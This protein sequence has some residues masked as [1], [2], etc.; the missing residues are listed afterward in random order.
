MFTI[1]AVAL[2]KKVCKLLQESDISNCTIEYNYLIRTKRNIYN[3]RRKIFPVLPKSIDDVHNIILNTM[4][5]ET[6]K[7][8]HFS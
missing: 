6:S 7:H 3:T 4:N 2:P 5:L 8:E 1:H